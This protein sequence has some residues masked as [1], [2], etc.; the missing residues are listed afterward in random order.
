MNEIIILPDG[1]RT[2]CG[3]EAHKMAN[4]QEWANIEAQIEHG[5]FCVFEGQILKAAQSSIRGAHSYLNPDRV[6]VYYHAACSARDEQRNALAEARLRIIARYEQVE[7][8]IN[9]PA[10]ESMLSNWSGIIEGL[11]QAR[12]IIGGM[13]DELPVPTPQAVIDHN[14][15]SAE[16]L[17]DWIDEV[18]ATPPT[19]EEEAA[20]RRIDERVSEGLGFP[21]GYLRGEHNVSDQIPR[22]QDVANTTDSPERLSA[23]VLFGPVA[24][25]GYVDPRLAFAIAVGLGVFIFWRWLRHIILGFFLCSQHEILHNLV[26]P[27]WIVESRGVVV[28]VEKECERIN[29]AEQIVRLPR[30][31]N[32]ASIKVSKESAKLAL[33]GEQMNPSGSEGF[34]LVTNLRV[35]N[36]GA[37]K[38]KV[39]IALGGLCN[40]MAAAL[41]DVSKV[42]HESSESNPSYVGESKLCP[43]ARFFCNHAGDFVSWPNAFA[44]TRER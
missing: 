20:L 1:S 38:S 40:L 31:I 26:N 35:G 8:W 2:I 12:R 16:A 42:A 9:Q 24:D 11:R 10:T 4:S 6:L 13:W 39:D 34:E 41:P 17:L 33:R 27:L 28:S 3:E 29:L 21:V 5:R 25:G 32:A 7:T 18:N 14:E 15:E 43:K 30:M 37:S 36:V 22:T 44:E 19:P 23:S